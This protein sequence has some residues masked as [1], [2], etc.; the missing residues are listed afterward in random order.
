MQVQKQEDDFVIDA[1]HLTDNDSLSEFYTEVQQILQAI[2][3]I[4][5]Y[6]REVSKIHSQI[7]ASPKA[8][9][10]SKRL[11]EDKMAEIKRTAS[12]VRQKLKDMEKH[13][14]EYQKDKHH[15]AE[16][17]IKSTQHSML[18]HRVVEVMTEYNRVQNEYREKYKARIVRQLE[19]TGR[20]VSGNDE[21]EEMLEQEN[22]NVFVQ[23]VC[24]V[25]GHLHSIDF[26]HQVYFS[27]LM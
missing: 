19:I 6:V 5:T 16:Y 23:G 21:I 27:F 15:T 14:A 10:N 11:L 13:L 18:E 20:S 26:T 22:P 4:G 1:N 8:D 3:I 2:D 25:D 24:I 7:L 9:E 12:R 17:R